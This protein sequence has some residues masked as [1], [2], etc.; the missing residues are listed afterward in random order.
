MVKILGIATLALMMSSCGAEPADPGEGAHVRMDKATS[1]L[2]QQGYEVMFAF[3]VSGDGPWSGRT[4]TLPGGGSAAVFAWCEGGDEG[5]RVHV[6]DAD[7][8]SIPCSEEGETSQIV[9]DFDYIGTSIELR[10]SDESR[11]TWALGVGV[12]S[13]DSESHHHE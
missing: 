8:G 7:V 12:P 5:P 1:A 2:E 6:D 4:N 11:T 9:D 13:E 3:H 10:G